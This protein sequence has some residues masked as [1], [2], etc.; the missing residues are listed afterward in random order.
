MKQEDRGKD[1][2]AGPGC[3]GKL[4]RGGCCWSSELKDKWE[5][6]SGG[7]RA[8]GCAHPLP[9][10]RPCRGSLGPRFTPE[11]NLST[12]TTTVGWKSLTAKERRA[13][14]ARELV[15]HEP[16]IWVPPE[17][18]CARSRRLRLA[19]AQVLCDHYFAG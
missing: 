2:R 10:P 12:G 15:L 18:A 9:N 6:G 16:G 3:Q 14:R 7:W 11:G 4:S 17:H 8:G 5:M 13:R 1:T 19:V